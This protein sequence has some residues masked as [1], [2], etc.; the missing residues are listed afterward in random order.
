VASSLSCLR[1]SGCGL[2]NQRGR[3]ES[4]GQ[5]WEARSFLLAHLPFLRRRESSCE[6]RSVGASIRARQQCGGTERAS[7]HSR[8]VLFQVDAAFTGPLLLT[9]LMEVTLNIFVRNQPLSGCAE[10]GPARRNA[11]S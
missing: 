5:G 3:R 10:A 8:V 4:L 6:C 11:G 1:L 2:E 9:N 7:L